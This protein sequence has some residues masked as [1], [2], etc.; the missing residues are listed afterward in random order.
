MFNG[1]EGMPFNVDRSRSTTPEE[2]TEEDVIKDVDPNLRAQIED[3][4]GKENVIWIYDPYTGKWGFTVRD[5]DD[6]LFTD[7]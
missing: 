3:R 6:D 5:N 7:D 2:L 4:Y 1:P